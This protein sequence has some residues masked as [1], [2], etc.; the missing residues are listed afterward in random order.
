MSTTEYYKRVGTPN[1]GSG[2]YPVPRGFCTEG[3]MEVINDWGADPINGLLARNNVLWSPPTK[4]LVL[5]IVPWLVSVAG[6]GTPPTVSMGKGS[7]KTNLMLANELGMS[8]VDDVDPRIGSGVYKFVDEG[9]AVNV[10]VTVA[11][12]GFTEYKFVPVII[13]MRLSRS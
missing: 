11:A 13:G 8:V 9:E 10:E 1:D 12:T 6:A 2:V 7:S 3:S 4:V 5:G